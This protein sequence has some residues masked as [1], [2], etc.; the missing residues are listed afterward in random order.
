MNIIIGK[1]RLTSGPKDFT[2]SEIKIND[3]EGSKNFGKEYDS[4]ST[5]WSS[6]PH[7]LE[8]LLK[9]RMLESDATTLEEL[10][11]GHQNARAELTSLFNAIV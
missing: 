7:A 3:T 9:R 6:L 1:Y 8:Y 5:Y 2:V 11:K 10:L 4:E